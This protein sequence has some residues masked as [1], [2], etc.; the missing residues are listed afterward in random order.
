MHTLHEKLN[1]KFF[2]EAVYGSRKDMLTRRLLLSSGS[3]AVALVYQIDR[4]ILS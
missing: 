3:Y 1:F 4:D 2:H